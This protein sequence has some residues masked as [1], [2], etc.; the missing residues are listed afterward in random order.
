MG[1]RRDQ[2]AIVLTVLTVAVGMMVASAAIVIAVL[3]A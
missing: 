1:S 3:A 2:M